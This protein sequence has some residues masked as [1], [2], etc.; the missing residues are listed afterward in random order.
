MRHVM[1][2]V[3]LGCVRSYARRGDHYSFQANCG[4]P[5]RGLTNWRLSTPIAALA[6]ISIFGGD[7]GRV[8]QVK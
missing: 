5:E 1:V 3:I 7:G 4:M 6:T 2:H 8:L